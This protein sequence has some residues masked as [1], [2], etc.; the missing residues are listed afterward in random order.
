M[1]NSND[2]PDSSKIAKEAAEN[3][4][5]DVSVSL[6]KAETKSIMKQR[7]KEMWQKQWEE[8][9]K[10]VWFY[11]IQRKLGETRCAGRSRREGTI[12]LKLRFG[13]TGLKSTLQIRKHDPGNCDYCGGNIFTN[14]KASVIEYYFTI[15]E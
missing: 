11:Q 4:C 6:S 14:L 7:L 9:R 8:D 12:I 13:H 1:Q 5:T 15:L 10:G 2:G 3:S